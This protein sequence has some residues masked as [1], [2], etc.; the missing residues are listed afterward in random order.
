MNLDASYQRMDAT[1]CAIDGSAWVSVRHYRFA[2][3][4][5]IL[6]D[7]RVRYR[8]MSLGV[9]WSVINPLVMLGVLLII[10]TFIHPNHHV[11]HFPV[12][13]LIG[14][15]VYNFLAQTLPPATSSI[16]DNA[17]LVKKVIFPRE[18]IPVSV[19]MSQLV[20]MGI[21]LGILFVFAFLFS[22]PVT[23]SWLWLVPCLLI[24]L[25][26]LFGVALISS[27][28][29][30]TFRDMLY[31]VESG[32]KVSFWLTPIFYD[33]AQVKLN[34]PRQLYWVY[35]LNPLAGC[36]D[37]VRSGL[38][39]DQAPD[40]EALGFAAVVSILTLIFGWWL[41]RQRQHRFSDSL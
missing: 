22:V 39:M 26:F 5:L 6:K 12:F 21:Q 41:F 40:P 1:G 20:H 8:N 16:M 14:L 11:V 9:L 32:L 29:Y 4:N 24:L 7:F 10:F 33:L 18:L 19:V 28:L 2:L 23:W 34:M 35:L 3:V 38:L 13:L 30:V 17:S 36:I 37:G 31:V 25:V 27:T 15:V